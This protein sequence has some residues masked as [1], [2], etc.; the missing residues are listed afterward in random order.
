M[1]SPIRIFA[2]LIPKIKNQV[3]RFFFTIAC[4]TICWAMAEGFRLSKKLVVSVVASSVN[5]KIP[6]DNKKEALC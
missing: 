4:S 5:I 2:R 1:A 3:C 6:P